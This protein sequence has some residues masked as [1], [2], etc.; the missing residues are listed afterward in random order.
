MH[1][2]ILTAIEKHKCRKEMVLSGH[3]TQGLIHI[4]SNK[5]IAMAAG[6]TPDEAAVRVYAY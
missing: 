1:G 5:S 4:V 6:V 3:T 2:G